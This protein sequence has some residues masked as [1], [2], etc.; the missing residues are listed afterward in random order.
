MNNFLTIITEKLT[1][2]RLS[3]QDIPLINSYAG[4]PKVAATTLNI[5]HPRVL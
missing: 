5:P 2:K 3:S 1:L 4:N